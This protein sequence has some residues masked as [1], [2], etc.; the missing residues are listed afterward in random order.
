MKRRNCTQSIRIPIKSVEERH[1]TSLRDSTLKIG[2]VAKI[3]DIPI[4]TLRFYENEGLIQSFAA[5][6]KQK[7]RHRR[8]PSSVFLHLELIK[9]CRS[10]GVSIPQIKSLMKLYRGYKLPSKVN[11]SALRRSID[12]IRE[13]KRKLSRIEKALL[14]R[15]RHPEE[16]LD[17][18]FEKKPDLF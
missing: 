6:K 3:S 18:L 11:M 13:Q 4:V 12:L 8:F 15:L 17:E 9:V 14:Y 5:D 7:Y 16:N 2:E 10:A 1:K